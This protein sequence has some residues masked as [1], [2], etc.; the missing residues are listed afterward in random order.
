MNS[1]IST[2]SHFEK[3]QVAPNKIVNEQIQVPVAQKLK[4]RAGQIKRIIE[5]T[6]IVENQNMF[7]DIRK[8][9]ASQRQSMI[10]TGNLPNAPEP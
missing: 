4:E 1:R 2:F 5:T 9:F 7:E 10:F 8:T 3:P 6:D